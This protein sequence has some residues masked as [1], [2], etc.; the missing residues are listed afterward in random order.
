MNPAFLIF[1]NAVLFAR[2]FVLFKDDAIQRRPWLIKTLVE[3]AVLLSLSMFS[4]APGWARRS[5]W[6]QPIFSAGVGK[7]SPVDVRILV[8]C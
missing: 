6:L 8:D 7:P 2:L 1:A 3:L 4:P 5:W